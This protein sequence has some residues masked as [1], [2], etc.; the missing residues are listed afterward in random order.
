MVRQE[1]SYINR[2]KRREKYKIHSIIL[3]ASQKTN[4]F[5]TEKG[6]K[7]IKELRNKDNLGENSDKKKSGKRVI[8]GKL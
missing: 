1:A 4:R 6:H 5:S 7:A 3:H 2:T 8:S